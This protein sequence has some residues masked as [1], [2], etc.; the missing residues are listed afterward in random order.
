MCHN[1]N[2]I[3]LGLHTNNVYIK[4][5]EWIDVLSIAAKIFC[6]AV[7]SQNLIWILAK[8]IFLNLKNI[9]LLDWI[10]HSSISIFLNDTNQKKMFN[11]FM[12]P[13][14]DVD[15]IFTKYILKLIFCF[16][17]S[18]IE[19]KKILLTMNYHQVPSKFV[20]KI[21]GFCVYNLLGKMFV[22]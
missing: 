12:W 21:V 17:L 18:E 6:H 22:I 13:S 1:V 3:G 15:C 4:T 10:L 20:C 9:S 14:K 7:F 5:Y 11:I 2:Y 8:I 16:R 19:Y